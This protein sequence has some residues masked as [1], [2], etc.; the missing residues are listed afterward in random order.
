[1]P[2]HAGVASPSVLRRAADRA[3]AGARGP[4]LAGAVLAAVGV[5]LLTAG[6]RTPDRPPSAA[7]L[8]QD[9]GR[10]TPSD[11]G[12]PSDRDA[13][14]G[15]GAPSGG[16]A[17][18]AAPDPAPRHTGPPSPA[19][20]PRPRP[21]WLEIASIGVR[22]PL[23][24]LGLAADGS[25]AMPSPT[26]H[27]PAGWYRYLASPGETGPAVIAGHVDSAHD[28][29]AVF[30]RLGALRPGNAIDV[31]RVDGLVAHFAVTEVFSVPKSRFPSATVYGPTDRPAL[32][33]VT[34]G[35]TFDRAT[36]HWLDSVVV[37]ARFTGSTTADG[38]ATGTV[39]S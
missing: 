3:P 21:L 5:L 29:P 26:A 31:G 2:P 32:R 34:C 18:W 20:H 33:L 9:A 25:L 12:A 4:A 36:G 19:P 6:A 17:S 7:P 22:T 37:L 13:P 24:E 38:A 39:Q 28:G 27:A 11:G 23:L 8:R 15:S 30:F 14:S 16:S 1:V 10:P 35:G